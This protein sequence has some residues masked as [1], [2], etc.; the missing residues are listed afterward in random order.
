MR[1][2][3]RVRFDTAPT[4]ARQTILG[5]GPGAHASGALLFQI[6]IMVTTDD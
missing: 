5:P 6:R 4:P 1:D 3:D 2:T